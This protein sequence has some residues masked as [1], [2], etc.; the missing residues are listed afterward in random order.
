MYLEIN[1]SFI[2]GLGMYP[3]HRTLMPFSFI[4]LITR[5]RKHHHYY[6]TLI[7]YRLKIIR[8]TSSLGSHGPSYGIPD[9]LTGPRDV[10]LCVHASEK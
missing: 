7:E 1:I 9:L 4:A 2:M 5:T 3:G 8:G 10:E 6:A